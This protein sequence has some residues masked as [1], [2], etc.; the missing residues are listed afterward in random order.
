M[1]RPDSAPSVVLLTGGV[2]GGRFARGLATVAAERGH[3]LTAIVNVGDDTWLTGLRVCPDLDS[4][5][6]ALAGVNDTDRGW[7]RAGES[8][9]VGA[10]LAAYGV[11]WPWFTL[12]DLDLGTHIARTALLRE[13]RSLTEATGVVNA[14]WQTGVDL[15]PVTDDE[16][17]T[18]VEFMGDD[19]MSQQVHFEEW[20]VRHR[21]AVPTTA[22]VHR[23]P[24]GATVSPQ[25]TEALAH[26]NVILLAPSNPVVSIGAMLHVGGL[27]QAIRR[28][29]APV[30]GL[31][32]VIGGRALR[33][34]AEVCCAVEGIDCT[35]D[36]I[37]R[38]YGAR[39]DGGLLDGW[40]M[41]ECDEAASEP[42]GELGMTVRAIPLLMSD[43]TSTEAM[44]EEALDLG[45]ALTR[46]P[47]EAL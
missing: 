17:E 15:L 1:T 37:A 25:V 11:G 16:A 8:T 13:G 24:R 4:V 14:R 43:D 47:E 26:A 2:G 5:M 44:A 22:F 28:S 46:V 12:G 27:R 6:Y 31:S 32:P 34:M 21:A 9:R 42:L 19:G 33:G 20:W 23:A 29:P 40:L 39:R 3:D 45:A 7:G 38:H 36:G 10:E 35:S 18:W 41:D 30:V